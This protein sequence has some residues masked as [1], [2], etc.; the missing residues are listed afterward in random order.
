MGSA[1][2]SAVGPSGYSLDDL[3]AHRS[4][5]GDLTAQAL[6]DLA[7]THFDVAWSPEDLAKHKVVQGKRRYSWWCGRLAIAPSRG[8]ELLQLR[9]ESSR[10]SSRFKLSCKIPQGCRRSNAKKH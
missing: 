8:R 1:A 5:T 3:L 9:S 10:S 4:A 6:C 7:Q 2:S